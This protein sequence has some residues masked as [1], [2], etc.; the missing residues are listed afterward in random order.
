MKLNLVKKDFALYPAT[1]EDAE[2]LMKIKRGQVYSCEVKLI[3]NY[4]FLKKYFALFNL[5]WEYLNEQEQ[6]NFKSIENLRKQI[7]IAAGHCE[8]V[9]SI[10]RNEFIE[11]AKS[12]SFSSVDEAEFSKIYESV[13]E[14]IFRMVLKGKISENDFLNELINF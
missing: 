11:Q 6:E 3:R 8:I 2:M 12:V 5:T 13:K 9:W 14:V 7:E 4:Q 10:K 1:D